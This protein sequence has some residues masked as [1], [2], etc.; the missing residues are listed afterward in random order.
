L[1]LNCRDIYGWVGRE[2]DNTQM[3]KTQNFYG[4]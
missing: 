1:V 4:P 2:L 3:I